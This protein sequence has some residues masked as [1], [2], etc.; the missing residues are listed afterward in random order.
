MFG[1]DPRLKRSGVTNS[2]KGLVPAL[3]V[4]MAISGPFHFGFSSRYTSR[5]KLKSATRDSGTECLLDEIFKLSSMPFC[6]A[7]SEAWPLS[8]QVFSMRSK[9]FS[10]TSRSIFH[11]DSPARSIRA[12]GFGRKPYLE[13]LP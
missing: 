8:D 9:A 11:F 1:L 3:L 2:L 13:K 5:T 10:A 12:D 6:K 7:W 4:L